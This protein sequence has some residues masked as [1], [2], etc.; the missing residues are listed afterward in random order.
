MATQ[1]FRS[2]PDGN[3]II[4]TLPQSSPRTCNACVERPA[5]REVSF[6][7]CQVRLAFCEPCASVSADALRAPLA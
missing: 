5:T 1:E 6:G 4:L 2:S 7:G 3:P